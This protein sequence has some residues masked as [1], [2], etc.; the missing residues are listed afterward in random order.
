MSH[1]FSPGYVLCIHETY[2]L[3]NLL[4]ITVHLTKQWNTS[5]VLKMVIKILINMED[6]HN[7]LKRLC[8]TA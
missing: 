6:G 3:I 1:R 5:Q 2:M 7:I 8:N 4:K